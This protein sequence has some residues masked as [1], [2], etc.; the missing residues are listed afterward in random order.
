MGWQGVIVF[1]DGFSDL[2][3][4]SSFINCCTNFINDNGKI[5]IFTHEDNGCIDNVRKHFGLETYGDLT[6]KKSIIGDKLSHLSI[7]RCVSN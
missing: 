1:F 7:D 2:K 3:E 6:L 5:W 4:C